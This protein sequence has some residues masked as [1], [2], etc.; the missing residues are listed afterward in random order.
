MRLDRMAY[1]DQSGLYAMEDMLQDLKAKNIDAVFV[2]LLNQ[3]RYMM[4]RIDIIPDFISED[5]I[6][7]D[8]DSC[9]SW[10]KDNVES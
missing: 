7:E 10:I 9:I 1:M 2:G 5:K 3:P 6:F 4:E 8:F